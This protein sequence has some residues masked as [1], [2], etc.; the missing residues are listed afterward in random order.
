MPTRELQTV[1]VQW[2]PSTASAG[3]MAAVLRGQDAPVIARIRDDAI[4]LDLRTIPELDFED[5]VGSVISVVSD[6]QVEGED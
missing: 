3:V 1:V 2:R 4:Y 6:S 5:L